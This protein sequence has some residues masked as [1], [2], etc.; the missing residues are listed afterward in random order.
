MTKLSDLFHAK[1]NLE[2]QNSSCP[3]TKKGRK[4][5]SLLLSWRTLT[6]KNTYQIPQ[7]EISW[8]YQHYGAIERWI[9]SKKKLL[10]PHVT[11][12]YLCQYLW[13]TTASS[14]HISG[15]DKL[16]CYFLFMFSVLCRSYDLFS[17]LLVG[18]LSVHCGEN[19]TPPKVPVFCLCR[20][21][22][23]LSVSS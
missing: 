13:A 20:K 23:V 1:K 21:F 2:T 16:L 8:Q 17:W 5:L 10:F 3:N 18:K 12:N 7:L 19:Q 15:I 9:Q 11:V 22:N 6:E 4:N 14:F